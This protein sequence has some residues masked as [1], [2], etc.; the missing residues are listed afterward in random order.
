MS[1]MDISMYKLYKNTDK[2]HPK[3]EH[4]HVVGWSVIMVWNLYEPRKEGGNQVAYSKG[5]SFYIR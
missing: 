3:P 4:V 1:V 2:L 5:E